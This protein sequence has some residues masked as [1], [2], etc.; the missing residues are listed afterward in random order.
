MASASDEEESF[1]ARRLAAKPW[2][3]RNIEI[4]GTKLPIS[5]VTLLM[6][7]ISSCWLI[8]FLFGG[9]AKEVYVEASHIL[10]TDLTQGKRQLE[11][12]KAEIGNNYE[13]FAKRASKI[14]MCPSKKSGG[15]LGRISPGVMA[16]TFDRL[17]FDPNSPVRTTLG[18]IQSPFG[19]HL[20]YIHERKLP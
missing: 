18:P 5:Y 7:W 13:L 12:L 14:S 15:N 10:V 16:P 2:Y 11:E 8:S 9:P 19:Y 1:E 20:V 17:C 3:V 4:Q 6:I